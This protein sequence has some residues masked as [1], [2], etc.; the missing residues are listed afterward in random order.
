MFTTVA[1]NQGTFRSVEDTLVCH[2]LA[3]SSETS[4]PGA[5]C[6]EAKEM[7]KPSRAQGSPSKQRIVHSHVPEAQIEIL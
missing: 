6:K 3:R 7:V 1:P 2:H 4:A 5:C